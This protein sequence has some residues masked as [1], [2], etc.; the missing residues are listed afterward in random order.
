MSPSSHYL[1]PWYVLI[2][3]AYYFPYDLPSLRYIWPPWSILMP[4]VETSL[5]LLLWVKWC[6]FVLPHLIPPSLALPLLAVRWAHMILSLVIAYSASSSI[7]AYLH[8]FCYVV[9]FYVLASVSVTLVDVVAVFCWPGEAVA[10]WISA[11]LTDFCIHWRCWTLHI[12]LFSEIMLFKGET[13]P[14]YFT[15][16]GAYFTLFGRWQIKEALPDFVHMFPCWHLY[17][18]SLPCSSLPTHLVLQLRYVYWH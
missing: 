13:L 10:M 18:S 3:S 4:L 1:F 5:R 16:L 7:S 14:K 6:Y 12:D 8:D 9:R 15:I 17:I 11:T 2:Y